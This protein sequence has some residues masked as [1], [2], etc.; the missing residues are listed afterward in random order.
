MQTESQS[1]PARV[2][3]LNELSLSRKR[4]RYTRSLNLWQWNT[5]H[6]SCFMRLENPL[7]VRISQK[8]TDKRIMGTISA[9]KLVI[10]LVDAIIWPRSPPRTSV[11][12]PLAIR[13]ISLY[14]ISV[15]GVN[16]KINAKLILFSPQMNKFH[17]YIY[18]CSTIKIKM[19][20]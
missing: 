2:D 14:F 11:A 4:L 12:S 10:R 3:S 18:M 1:M 20:H 5:V 16:S 9:L 8:H 15:L 17:P 7:K 19:L 13:S 6:S